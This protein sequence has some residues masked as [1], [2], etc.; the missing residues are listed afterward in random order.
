MTRVPHR[1]GAGVHPGGV[2][3]VSTHDHAPGPADGPQAEVLPAVDDEPKSGRW[4]TW[5]RPVS[6]EEAAEGER[7]GASIDV[8]D[9]TDNGL[10][11]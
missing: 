9:D 1:G 5:D 8:D 6:D 11:E 7:L 3:D 10:G 4:V 2:S